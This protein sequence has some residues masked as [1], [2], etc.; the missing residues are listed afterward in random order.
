M[1]VE[2]ESKVVS[3][4][5]GFVLG[6]KDYQVIINES[7]TAIEVGAYATQCPVTGIYG[8]GIG[9]ELLTGNVELVIEDTAQMAAYRELY[10][11]FVE[12]KKAEN[13]AEWRAKQEKNLHF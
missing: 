4:Q 10:K 9:K 3:R 6:G 13:K 8:A 12:K 1:Q 5:I 2:P 7:S 11:E